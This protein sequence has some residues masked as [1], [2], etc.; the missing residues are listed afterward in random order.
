MVSGVLIR[1][2]VPPLTEERR[3][4]LVKVVRQYGEKA[5]VSLR[6]FR[7]EANQQ[8]KNALKAGEISQDE[9]KIVE[10]KIQ[11]L[12]DRY[13]AEV[14]EMLASKEKDIMSV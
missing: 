9:E 4:N 7:R 14:D 3:R 5:K 8:I 12:T 11:Q 13:I 1:V 10:K 6:S 2:P